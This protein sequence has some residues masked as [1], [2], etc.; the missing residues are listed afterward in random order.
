MSPQPEDVEMDPALEEAIELTKQ[1]MENMLELDLSDPYPTDE[2]LIKI[3]YW[4]R[5]E[6]ACLVDE[7]DRYINQHGRLSFQ[8]GTVEIVTGGWSGVESI[9]Y[10]MKSNLSLWS[11][12]WESTHKGGL[13][14]FKYPPIHDV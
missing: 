11:K 13:Y 12:H 3:N 6:F 1:R 9:I 10:A 4:P 2:D 5:D 14:I 8:E 7:V